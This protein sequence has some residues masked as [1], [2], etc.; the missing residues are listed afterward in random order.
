[1]NRM[2]TGF[3]VMIIGILLPLSLL[4]KMSLEKY[5]SLITYNNST[6]EMVLSEDNKKKIEDYNKKINLENISTVDPF[7]EKLHNIDDEHNISSIIDRDVLA[8]LIIPK[9]NVLEEIRIGATE[10][11]LSLG[12]AQVK[13]TSLPIGGESTRSVLA[14]HR[15][16]YNALRFFRLNELQKGDMVYV[17]YFDNILAYEVNNIEI[18]EATNWK[19]LEIEKN[20]DMLT[21]LTCEPLVPPFNYR[22]LVNC[23]RKIISQEEVQQIDKK[24]TKVD[25]ITLITIFL[26][27]IVLFLVYKFFKISRK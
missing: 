22:L 4:T 16:D 15:S 19:K 11:N 7:G 26:W 14:A 25:F 21:L 5:S 27:G 23:E 3:I 12:V 2:K 6:N 20:K 24:I 10:R 1:M 13:G 17:R 8:Y 9:I 18:I